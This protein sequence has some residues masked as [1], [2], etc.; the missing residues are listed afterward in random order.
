[1][2]IVKGI[3]RDVNDVS[4]LRL[5]LYCRA[6]EDSTGREKSVTDQETDGHRWAEARGCEVTATFTD[7]DRSA[8]R[9]ATKARPE[10]DRLVKE[11]DA[12][13]IDIVWFWELS[14]SQRRLDVF[15][16]LRDLCRARGVLWVVAGRVYDLTNYGDL[17]A[18]GFQAVNG[19]VE[20]ELISER[21]RRGQA[22]SAA[23]GK[24]HGK[25]TYGY[26]RVY[27]ERGRYVRQES[28]E[29]LREAVGKDGNSFRYSTAAVIREIFTRVANGDPLIT[30]ERSLN[31]RGIPSPRE[32]EGGWR[33]GAIRKMVMSPTYIGRRVHQGEVLEI[34]AETWPAL[35]SEEVFYAA[36]NVLNDPART[37]TKP[38]RASHLLSYLVRCAVCGKFFQYTPPGNRRR[39]ATYACIDRCA[40]INAADLDAYVSWIIVKYL[41][42][43]DVYDFLMA[44]AS[45]DARVAAARAECERLRAE[46]EDWRRLAE[47]GE[48]TAISFARTEK[49]LLTRIAEEEAKTTGSS[50]PP[51]LRGRIGEAAAEGW[52]RADLAVKR[53]IIRLVADI[54]VSPAG[55]GRRNVPIRQ[56][57]AGNWRWLIGPDEGPAPA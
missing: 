52:E 55:K 1:M 16:Q 21:V 36:Q 14:R 31:G 4:G 54:R 47:Q 23:A 38:A 5:A 40:G 30:I 50:L 41:S 37:T 39:Q 29:V 9:F 46:L 56:R 20:S 11:I 32:G 8:S 15:A 33:R 45:D 12:G 13:Q 57:I 34:S 6:S 18:L 42:R 17:M 43:Q 49:G 27:D 2:K 19:E 35:V 51:V 24:P 44:S 22:S 53:E 48:V 3:K 10:F 7:N 28:D 25:L 26:R